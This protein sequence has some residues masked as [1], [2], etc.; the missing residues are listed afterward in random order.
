[1]EK[2]ANKRKALKG[3]HYLLLRKGSDNFYKEH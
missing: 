3:T 2:D 1:M